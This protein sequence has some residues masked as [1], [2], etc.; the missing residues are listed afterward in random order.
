[1]NTLPLSSPTPLQIWWMA[2]RPKTLVAGL[3]PVLLGHALAERDGYHAPGAFLVALGWTLLIQIA[4]N[5]NND[6]CDFKRGADTAERLGPV[7]VTQSGLL[8]QE[9]VLAATVFFFALAVL[10]GLQL[11]HMIGPPALV[12]VAVS[13]LA[14]FAYT[15]GPYPLGYNGLGDVAVFIFFGLVPVALT[16]YVEAGHFSSLVW[17]SALVPGALG[18]AILTVNN[19]RDV[20]TDRVVGKR[21]LVVLLGVGFGRFQYAAVLG[22]TVLT[23]VAM[24]AMG[25]VGPTILLPLLSLPLA[26]SPLRRVLTQ[27]GASLNEAL[28]ET[29]RF[30]LAFGLLMGAGLWMSTAS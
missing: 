18:I 9:A 27:S 20:K 19:L 26:L 3:V 16:Y 29:A 11:V 8:S 30:E 28:G 17:M 14:A 22:I 5:L 1:M 10:V 23:P 21:T 6:Y 13:V 12:L 4:C 15:G 7:R 24:W 25:L 2:I